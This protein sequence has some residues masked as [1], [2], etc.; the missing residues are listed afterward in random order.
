[1]TLPRP[2]CTDHCASCGCH[3]HGLGAFDLHRQDGE[4]CDP[5]DVTATD[6][7]SEQHPALQVWTDTGF[8]RWQGPSVRVNSPVAIWQVWQSPEHREALARLHA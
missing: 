6:R 7:N 8:C 2:F 1:M 4:C 3:F 5:A